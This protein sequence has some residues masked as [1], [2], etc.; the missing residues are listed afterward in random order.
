M[1]DQA[2]AE[3]LNQANAERNAQREREGKNRFEVSLRVES[4][5]PY[6]WEPVF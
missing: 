4:A 6:A 2:K 5:Q 3:A 1:V